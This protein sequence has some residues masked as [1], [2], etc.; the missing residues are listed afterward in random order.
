MMLRGQEVGCCRRARV[1][2]LHEQ[3]ACVAAE[4]S[5]L[6]AADILAD[7]HVPTG[8]LQVVQASFKADSIMSLIK[9]ACKSAA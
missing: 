9:G 2:G 4:P 6:Q 1:E 7:A 5:A 8:Q 3:A